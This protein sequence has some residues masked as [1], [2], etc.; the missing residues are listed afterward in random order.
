MKVT[1]PKDV[2][3]RIES[4][5]QGLTLEVL[6]KALTA[7]GLAHLQTPVLA[8]PTCP[9]FNLWE[10]VVTQLRADLLAEG[11]TRSDEGG[12]S[13]VISPCGKLRI[14]SNGGDD[15]TGSPEETANPTTRSNKGYQ[16]KASIDVN[17]RQYA[18]SFMNDNVVPMRT[19]DRATTTWILLTKFT[20]DTLRSELSL[21]GDCSE[22]T[23]RPIG[24]IERIP[25][26]P[27][28]F[29]GCANRDMPVDN[30]PEFEV[31]IERK[32]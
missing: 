7:G 5:A 2:S 16:T 27:L 31:K 15:L 1:P 10:A 14:A 11:W 28:T 32:L 4:L 3:S 25:L 18:F 29:D 17:R 20:D 8:P 22:K 21:P 9:G 26:P 30:G 19:D 23:G 13:V 24:W 12:Y 6:R